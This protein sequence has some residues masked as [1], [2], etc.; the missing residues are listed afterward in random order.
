[1]TIRPQLQQF[2]KT[3][4]E[5]CQF[6]VFYHFFKHFPASLFLKHLENTCKLR[7]SE[8]NFFDEKKFMMFP[9]SRR[10]ERTSN[11]VHTTVLSGADSENVKLRRI[12]WE[13]N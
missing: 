10:V 8:V 11:R 12:A 13:L 6:Q 1:M 5:G 4:E 9:K 7:T 2:S 3:F